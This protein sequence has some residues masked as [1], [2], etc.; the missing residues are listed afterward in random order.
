VTFDPE[1]ISFYRLLEVFFGIHD[2]TTL[3][4]QG[5]DIGTQYRSAIF[6]HTPEQKA[7]AE[8]MIREI[9]ASGTWGPPIVTEIK[10][11]TAFYP[12]E[13]YHQ[14]YYRKNPDQPY[15]QTVIAPKLAKVRQGQ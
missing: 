14:H 5:A 10:P 1:V 11:L 15:C 4:Q 9:E 7:E 3:N 2:P 13:D 12:A 8:R 6:Y